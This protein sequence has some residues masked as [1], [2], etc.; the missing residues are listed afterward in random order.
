MLDLKLDPIFQLARQ[1]FRRGALKVSNGCLQCAQHGHH[2]S[3]CARD[4]A[5]R[6]LKPYPEDDGMD[7]LGGRRRTERWVA[8][9]L[10][11]VREEGDLLC[12]VRVRHRLLPGK[13]VR[14][15]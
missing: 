11:Q 12:R 2:A 6:H 5:L 4:E 1:D 7:L 15:L 9:V 3:R 13:R 8:F 14:A 10:H